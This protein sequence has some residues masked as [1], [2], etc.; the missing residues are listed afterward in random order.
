MVVMMMM[1]LVVV[2]VVVWAGVGKMATARH[3]WAVVVAHV[4]VESASVGAG[5]VG[6]V[7]IAA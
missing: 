5:A 7:G 3:V 2:L 1:V 4:I 6:R